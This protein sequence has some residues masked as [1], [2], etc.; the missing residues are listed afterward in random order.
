MC[1]FLSAWIM[2]PNLLWM[3]DALQRNPGG[4]HHGVPD[5]AL[6]PH[7]HDEAEI[8]PVDLTVEIKRNVSG[9]EAT[10]IIKAPSW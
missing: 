5:E 7:L 1:P 3:P 9:I 4:P 2:Y 8:Q 10:L 6:V